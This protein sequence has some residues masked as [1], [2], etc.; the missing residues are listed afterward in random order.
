MKPC[1][2][3]RPDGYNPKCERCPDIDACSFD[4]LCRVLTD[5]GYKI[6]SDRYGSL[7]HVD[8]LKE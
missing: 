2:G 8:K 4:T 7:I 3:N 1:F 5:E 6:T